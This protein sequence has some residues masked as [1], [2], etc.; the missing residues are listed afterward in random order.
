MEFLNKL[1]SDVNVNADVG[2]NVEIDPKTSAILGL[3]I[4]AG[5]FL[6]LLLAGLILKKI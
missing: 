2:V 3:S 4:F 5:V 1:L 6:A